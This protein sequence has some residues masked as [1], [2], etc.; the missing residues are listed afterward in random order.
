LIILASNGH[1]EMGGTHST[2]RADEKCIQYFSRKNWRDEA[3]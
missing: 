1:V 3:T 2:Y